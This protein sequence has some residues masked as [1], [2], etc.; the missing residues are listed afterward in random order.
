M[1]TELAVGGYLIHATVTALI[2][3]ASMWNH[4]HDQVHY[5]ETIAATHSC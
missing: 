5:A 4:E 3:F 1:S 2:G